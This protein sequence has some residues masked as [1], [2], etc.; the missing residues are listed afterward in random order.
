[1]AEA[2]SLEIPSEPVCC[3]PPSKAAGDS[4]GLVNLIGIVY[5]AATT[6]ADLR[7]WRTIPKNIYA[8]RILTPDTGFVTVRTSEGRQLGDMEV[9]PGAF[10]LLVVTQAFEQ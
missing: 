10:N 8:A 5:Q 6:A 9:V 4:A 7:S 2:S 3:I 1:M